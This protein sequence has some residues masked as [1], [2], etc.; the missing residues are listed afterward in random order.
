[1][2]TVEGVKTSVSMAKRGKSEKKNVWIWV[3]HGP[4]YKERIGQRVIY[5]V[6]RYTKRNGLEGWVIIVWVETSESMASEKERE[7][8]ATLRP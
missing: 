5:G 7:G 2:N 4:K 3:E 8:V 1:M 6:T